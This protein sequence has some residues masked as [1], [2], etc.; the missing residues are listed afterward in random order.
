MALGYRHLRG[1]GVQQSCDKAL[2]H[3]EYAANVAAAQIEARGGF[4]VA[5]VHSR[6]SS[7]TPWSTGEDLEV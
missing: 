6:L 5:G 7:H 4:P 3:Y 2:L 1:L